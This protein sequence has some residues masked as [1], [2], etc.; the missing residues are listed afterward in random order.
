MIAESFCLFVRLFVG[1]GRGRYH[2]PRTT[3]DKKCRQTGVYVMN[4]TETSILTPF[5]TLTFPDTLVRLK[6]KVMVKILC[7]MVYGLA[8]NSYKTMKILSRLVTLW[9][10]LWIFIANRSPWLWAL[11]GGQLVTRQ[12]T[13]SLSFS[14][15]TPVTEGACA[16]SLN[17]TKRR[18]CSQSSY[19]KSPETVVSDCSQ[20]N[21]WFQT[22]C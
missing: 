18:E 22:S 2:D 5:V 7:T 19:Q 6:V 10:P 15:T 20:P 14:M 8:G 16:P 4:G 3:S 13:S 21:S 11:V 12:T 17:L 9:R 1:S